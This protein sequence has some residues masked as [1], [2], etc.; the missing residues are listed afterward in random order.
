MAEKRTHRETKTKAAGI[1]GKTEVPI[2]RGRR[3]DA[4]TPSRAVE[5]ET[6]GRPERLTAAAR[7]LGASRRSQHVLV[8][9]QTDM[10]K[11]RQAMRKVGVSGTVRNISGTKRSSVKTTAG[12]GGGR[13]RPS[14]RS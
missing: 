7:R 3:L 5:V 12:K 8:V 2:P 4:A 14:K 11:A 9:P 13:A 10:P 6:S 1:K